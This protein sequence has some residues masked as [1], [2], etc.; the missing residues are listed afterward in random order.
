[1]KLFSANSAFA[2]K[3]NIEAEDI[4]PIH[5]L[6]FM[7]AALLFI[8]GFSILYALKL[9]EDHKNHPNHNRSPQ[10]PLR[11]HP[12]HYGHRHQLHHR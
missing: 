8:V 9:R 10:M 1:M 6:I 7:V 4:S 12:N 2:Q 3:Q 11:H 5:S